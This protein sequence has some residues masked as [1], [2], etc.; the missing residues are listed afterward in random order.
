[1]FLLVEIYCQRSLFSQRR[2]GPVRK[3]GMWPNLL[4]HPLYL[5]PSYPEEEKP[6]YVA[7]STVLHGTTL[8]PPRGNRKQTLFCGFA[9]FAWFPWFARFPRCPFLPS[10]VFHPVLQKSFLVYK[11]LFFSENY[12]KS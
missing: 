5:L 7:F 1:M 10:S 2:A 9:R 6:A 12:K 8:K 4:T 11:K 3:F